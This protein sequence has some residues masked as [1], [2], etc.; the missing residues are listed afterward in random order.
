MSASI[1]IS[2]PGKPRRVAIV[3]SNPSVS[4]Q[5]G[6]AIGCWWAELA[7]PYYEFVN[8]GYEVDIYSP[9]GGKLQGDGM[10]DPRDDLKLMA[11]DLISLGFINSPQH[12]AL[13]EN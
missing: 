12:S 10:S 1:D 4:K 2:N 8:H 9:D 11:D 7:H 13:V 3:A 5:T 6:W